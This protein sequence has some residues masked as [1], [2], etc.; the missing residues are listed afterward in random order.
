MLGDYGFGPLSERNALGRIKYLLVINGPVH[1]RGLPV[2][3]DDMLM[4]GQGTLGTC[5]VSSIKG[6]GLVLECNLQ[7][8]RGHGNFRIVAV[9]Y[10]C[11]VIILL[12][13]TL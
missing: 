8:I 3:M 2:T 10:R 5:S 6:S 7:I 13:A 12:A 4:I 9:Q 11:F 1:L